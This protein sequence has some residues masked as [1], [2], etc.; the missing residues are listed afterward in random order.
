MTDVICT[1]AP[2]NIK[3]IFILKLFLAEIILMQADS[4][5][6]VNLYNISRIYLIR[7]SLLII[8]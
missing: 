7:L 2:R 6:S 4:Y 8:K 3:I 5:S 1:G